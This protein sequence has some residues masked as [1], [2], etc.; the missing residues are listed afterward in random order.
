MAEMLTRSFS[1]GS[2]EYKTT[3]FTICILLREVVDL[4]NLT[5]VNWLQERI[6]KL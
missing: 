4:T 1:P 3:A 6:D 2:M 5:P